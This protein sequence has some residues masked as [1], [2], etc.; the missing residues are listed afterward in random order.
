MIIYNLVNS[1]ELPV[2]K[3]YFLNS[4]D[5]RFKKY[6]LDISCQ[7]RTYFNE[8]DNETLQLFTFPKL[9]Q[10]ELDGLVKLNVQHVELTESGRSF[11]RNICM[12]FDLH[13]LNRSTADN[14]LP[15]L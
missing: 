4:Q 12:A 10:L 14:K 2:K 6:I 13:L 5:E 8:Q 1:K 15:H 3:G 9:R 11:I 7:G